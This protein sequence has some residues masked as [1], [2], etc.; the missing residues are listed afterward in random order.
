MEIQILPGLPACGDTHS[1]SLASNIL[2]SGYTHRLHIFLFIVNSQF[3]C[4]MC[5]IFA[6]PACHLTSLCTMKRL[7][8]MLSG[9]ARTA[10]CTVVREAC[11][12]RQEVGICDRG[13]IQLE[14]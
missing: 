11:Q 4:S 3:T 2:A 9:V 5:T 8:P 10:W 12:A 7:T 13:L 14:I 6:C 1:F